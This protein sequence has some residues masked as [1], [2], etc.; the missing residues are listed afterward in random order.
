M[1]TATMEITFECVPMVAAAT[2]RNVM[3]TTGTLAPVASL[4]STLLLMPPV[5]MRTV[6]EATSLLTMAVR[7]TRLVSMLT[8]SSTLGSYVTVSSH[9]SSAWPA[10]LA[11]TGTVTV[12]PRT[13]GRC[14]SG[15]V[16][17]APDDAGKSGS[18]WRATASALEAHTG[19][20]P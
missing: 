11:T 18:I 6:L 3:V 20:P 12:S 17:P 15:R 1:S 4:S 14:G 8:Y 7:K 19:T 10:V 16:M 13:R 9:T 2:T 5:V